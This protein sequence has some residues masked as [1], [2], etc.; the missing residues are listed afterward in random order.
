MARGERTV[1]AAREVID[2]V[3]R[4]S[5]VLSGTT[6]DD[7]TGCRVLFKVETLNPIRCF[8][9]RG[10]DLLV[11]SRP[12]DRPLACASA[13]NFG[14]GV[15]YAARTA[16]RPAHVFAPVTASPVKVAA[17]RQLGAAVHLAGDDFDAAKDIAR[18]TAKDEGWDFVEDGREPEIA[19]GAG[20][21]AAEVVEAGHR[22]DVALVPVGN[23]ALILG[24]GAYLKATVPGIR[25]VGVCP[26]GAPAM[27][28]SY[29]TGRAVSTETV[30]TVADGLAVRV[31]VLEILEPL[32]ET[33]D[34]MVTVSDEAMQQ[35]V[36]C[37]AE[38]TGLVVETSGAA[39]LAHL[40][41]A[42]PST[43]TQR[44]RGRTVFTPLCG[45][46]VTPR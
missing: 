37:L 34:E 35:A 25:I 14:Q 13:G 27:A 22:P 29:R 21:M 20:T 5:T 9:G 2:P 36:A 19:V 8:K 17:I 42:S 40:L 32:A 11:K 28:L 45:G 10:G 31:P 38:H 1:E 41:G 46:N 33:V 4:D 6:L 43:W 15:A 23:G 44:Y 39:G 12:G 18:A 24:V 3:F 16:G 7:A 30:E 26:Q